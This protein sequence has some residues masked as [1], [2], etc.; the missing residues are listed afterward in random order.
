M[1]ALAGAGIEGLRLETGSVPEPGPGEALVRFRALTL[2]YRDLIG[3]EGR[4]PG[5]TREPDYIPLSCGVGEV[6]AVGAGVTRVAP[7]QRVSPIFALGWRHGGVEN[8][9]RVHLGGRADGVARTHA[10]FDAEDLVHVPD[11]LG[12]LEAATLPCAGITAW[13]AVIAGRVKPGDLVVV[14]GTGGV[15]LAA[16]QFAKAAG[17]EVAI[18]SSSDAKLARAQALGADILVNYRTHPDWAGEIGRLA[19]RRANLVVDVVGSAGLAQSSAVLDD[20]GM[21]AAVGM[22]D[23]TFNWGVESAVN[24]KPVTVGSRDDNEA[25]LRACVTARIRPPVDRVFPLEQLGDALRLLKNGSFFGKIG[26]A[27]P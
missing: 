5:L 4:L 8:A 7:G 9:G 11:A 27:V 16:L 13:S 2:N 25:M 17:A 21:I 10:V 23:G 22:L 24:I 6:A 1:V 19:R 14:Q 3:V 15:S 20:N 26:V 12:D 18:T